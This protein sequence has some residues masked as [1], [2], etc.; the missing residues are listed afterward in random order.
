M[1]PAIRP[2]THFGPMPYNLRDSVPGAPI[3][4]LAMP[5][6]DNVP[7]DQIQSD[8]LVTIISSRLDTF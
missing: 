6:W 2:S 8:P 4:T 3:S 5:E 7:L 1:N